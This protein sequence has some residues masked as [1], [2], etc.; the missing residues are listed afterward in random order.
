MYYKC[1]DIIDAVKAD[2]IRFIRVALLMLY[3][4]K[5]IQTHEQ[6]KRSSAS[7]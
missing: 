2:F 3:D 6:I 7:L 5:Y 1:S 4:N